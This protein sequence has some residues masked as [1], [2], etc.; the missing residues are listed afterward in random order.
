MS[1]CDEAIARVCARVNGP[2][3]EALA[4]AVAHPDPECVNFFRHGAPLIGYLPYTENGIGKSYAEHM[5]EKELN[6]GARSWNQS[7][8]ES[9]K[10]D[11]HSS[12]LM[13]QV[14]CNL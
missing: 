13:L 9:L 3:L 14:C 1:G 12:T 2:A 11:E 10:E 7:L 6:D 4:K 8:L 5:S